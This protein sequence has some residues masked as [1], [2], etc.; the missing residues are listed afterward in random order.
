MSVDQ[1]RDPRSRAFLQRAWPAIGIAAALVLVSLAACSTDANSP[2]S[3]TSPA[4]SQAL[5]ERQVYASVNAHRVSQGLAPLAWSDAIADQARQHSE[6]MAAGAA[7]FGHDG[8][9]ERWDIIRQ[10]IP[11]AGAAEVVARTPTATAEAVLHTW[12]ASPE[13][14]RQIEADFTV[15]GVGTA[16]GP[17]DLYSTQIL[18][19]PSGVT[20]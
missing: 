20:P 17:L 5:L 7:A 14:K 19:K 15:T 11:W 16:K 8:V 10:S 13:H 3:P 4:N 9:T 12:L 1:R 6:D 18:I 2:S